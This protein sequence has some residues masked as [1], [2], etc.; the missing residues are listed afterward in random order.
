V[1]ELLRVHV[2]V[3]AVLADVEAHLGDI[4]AEGIV[5]KG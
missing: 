5:A 4:P 2:V 3:V 1:E